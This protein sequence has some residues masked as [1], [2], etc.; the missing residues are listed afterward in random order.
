MPNVNRPNGFKPKGTLSGADWSVAVRKYSVAA[1]NASAIGPGDAV[2][3][4]D[5]G[6]VER[7]AAGDALLG[8]CVGV[9]VD[10]AVAATVHPGYLPAS[11]AGTLLVTVGRD[12]IYE[13]QEDNVGGSMVAANVGSTGD[14]VAGAVSTTTGLSGMLL[15][16][17]DV[18]A[19]DA[20][21]ASAQFYVVGLSAQ[22]DN[23]I[24]TDAKWLV[25][26]NESQ[27]NLGT[28]GL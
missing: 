23:E 1:A 6:T 7:A 11:T 20:V 8:V 15:D 16:S 25:M 9:V 3:L 24:G 13:V 28:I 26:I 5:G 10:A 14:L 4:V 19:K 27:V 12:V 21:P 17:S 22:V 2:K 18:I